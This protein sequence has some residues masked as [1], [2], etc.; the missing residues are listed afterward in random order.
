MILFDI[1]L[2]QC[3]QGG[4]LAFPAFL[5]SPSLNPLFLSFTLL[6]FQGANWAVKLTQVV[7][8]K[9][10]QHRSASFGRG[11]I[12]QP[13]FTMP[14]AARSV[15]RRFLVKQLQVNTEQAESQPLPPTTFGCLV[16]SRL[17]C[18]GKGA[19][20]LRQT[21]LKIDFISPCVISLKRIS[22]LNLATK[23]QFTL[24][25]NR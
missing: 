16:H 24:L 18:S 3:H 10:N 19:A 15:G 20:E 8:L 13:F 21:P 2:V 9:Q 11:R 17:S 25:S 22:K 7:K 4:T 12:I 6:S 14:P 23:Q 1:T 5:P